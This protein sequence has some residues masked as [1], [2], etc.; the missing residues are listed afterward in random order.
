MRWYDCSREGCGAS[1]TVTPGNDKPRVCPR[2]GAPLV[3]VRRST[4]NT[5][6]K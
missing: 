3:E 2:C 6:A 4:G 5:G 1:V